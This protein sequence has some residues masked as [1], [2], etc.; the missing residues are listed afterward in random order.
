MVVGDGQLRVVFAFVKWISQFSKSSHMR[1]KKESK[2]DYKW[3]RNKIYREFTK[4]I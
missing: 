1:I 2:S 3:K 4:R